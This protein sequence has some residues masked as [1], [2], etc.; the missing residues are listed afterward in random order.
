MHTR[1]L[2]LQLFGSLTVCLFLV[3]V[4]VAQEA[5]RVYPPPGTLI[6]V[7]GWRLHLN[8]TG[9][10]ERNTPTVVLEAGSGDFSVDWQLVQP[11]VARFSRVC[12]Y[13]RAGSG[14]SDLGPRPRTMKQ[15]AYELHT[16]LQ[17]AGEKGPFVLV[18]HSLGGL[19][20]RVYVA[21][22]PEEVTGVVL[23]DGTSDDTVILL[24][25]KRVRL[26]ENAQG[27]T[28]PAI[29]T[30]ITAAEKALS[31]E[32]RQLAQLAESNMYGGKK[33]EI[34]APA[35]R[36]PYDRLPTALQAERLWVLTQPRY[37]MAD[38]YPLLSEEF[39][40]LYAMRKEQ[41]YSLGDRP[42][43][44]LLRKPVD[45]NKKVE[46]TALSRNSKL[47]VAEH[48]GHHIHLDEPAIV[49]GAI[50]EAVEAAQRHA[51]LLR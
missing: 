51:R 15:V 45:E 18:G 46:F 41:E 19:I 39:A 32:E 16:A 30:T 25:H 1:N 33:E 2:S 37:Y 44:V 21:D 7:G 48:S 31:E 4:G 20:V 24:N 47:I 8:C 11:E 9:K 35:I 14:W 6:D 49:T 26:R 3:G 40:A 28:L 5:T 12:S 29:R 17:K 23:V 42:L 10:S 27:R 43:V 34:G 22:Y 36:A 38:S 13:D 50:K